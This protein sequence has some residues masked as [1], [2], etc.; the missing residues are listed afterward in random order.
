M[1][2]MHQAKFGERAQIFPYLL[3]ACH[4]HQMNMGSPI[5]KFLN[6][7]LLGFYGGFIT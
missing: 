7:F 4:S 1:K 5:Q 6:P 3:P 2:E